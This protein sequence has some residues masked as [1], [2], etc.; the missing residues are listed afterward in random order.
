[1]NRQLIVAT[2]LAISSANANANTS[3]NAKASTH[4]SASTNEKLEKVSA[5]D[6]SRVH[7]LDEVCVVRQPKEQFLLRRQGVSSTMLSAKD[8]STLHVTDL[9]E[10]SSYVPNCVMS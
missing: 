4:A 10:L 7:E 1:M 8:L 2:L 9:R 3:T 5:L 6:S